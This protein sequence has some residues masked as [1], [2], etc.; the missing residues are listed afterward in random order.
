[1]KNAIRTLESSVEEQQSIIRAKVKKGESFSLNERLIG[2]F[3][4]AIDHLKTWKRK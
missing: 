2:E 3:Y 1:M 4:T